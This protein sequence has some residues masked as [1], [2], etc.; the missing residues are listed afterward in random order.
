MKINKEKIETAYNEG[1]EAVV[2]LIKEIYEEF[3]KQISELQGINLE[4]EAR[5]NKNSSNSSKPPSSDGYTKPKNNRRK[6]GKKTGGQP[7][8]QGYTLNKVE[9]P[10]KV[11]DI[12]VSNCECGCDLTNVKGKT[13]SRQVFDIPEVK[14]SVSEYVIHE[15]VC[16]KC[17]KFNMTEFPAEVKFSTQYGEG[18]NTLMNYLTCY[19]LLPLNRAVETI[20]DITGQHISEAT[21]VNSAQNLYDK[22]DEMENTIKAKIKESD[23]V[24][25]DETGMRSENK[26]KWLHVA[27]TEYLTYYAIQDKRS[28]KAIEEIGILPD[29]EGVA[30]HDNYK[31]YYKFKKCTHSECNSHN[32][33]YL[34][35][36]YE[37]YHQEWAKSMIDLLIDIKK[38]VDILKDAGNTY[39]E[40]NEIINWQEKYHKIIKDGINEDNQK[41]PKVFSKKTGKPKRSKALNL[42][43]K[44]QKYD[45][46]T[47]AFMYDFNVPFDNNLAERDLRMQKLRQKISGCFRGKRGADIFCRIRG[48]ISTARKNGK[49]ALEA[50]TDAIRGKPFVPQV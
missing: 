19:Q 49:T 9:N 13:K 44:L 38:R 10:D 23:V 3:S 22:L 43:L 29:F 32:L 39:M 46:E 26:T 12:D 21:L 20:K 33:R 28:T 14:I 5:L 35:D 2:E 40:S 18:I 15:K 6:T 16:P 37:N 27:S 8:H 30:V 50:L 48:Y 11:I 31:T 1:L 4:Q 7:G 17:G 24:H 25:F 41:S 45:I 34:S 36:I 42:L 47:L